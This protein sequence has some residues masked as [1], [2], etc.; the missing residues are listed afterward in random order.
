MSKLISDG[1]LI[2]NGYA[3]EHAGDNLDSLECAGTIG[4]FYAV[5]SASGKGG[6]TA[7]RRT[8]SRAFRQLMTLHTMYRNNG[9]IYDSMEAGGGQPLMPV[10][11]IQIQ[12]GS[13]VFLG[14]FDEFGFTDS[15]DKPF[16]MDYTFKFTC[17]AVNLHVSDVTRA[18]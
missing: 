9:Y 13:S 2:R 16:T 5:D 10:A 15:E 11:L 4:A 17:Y 12:F 18:S 8:S 6:L 3:V 7:C 14:R 1:D